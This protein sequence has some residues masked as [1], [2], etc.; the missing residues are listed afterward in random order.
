MSAMIPSPDELVERARQATGLDDF[1]PEGWKEGLERLHVAALSDLELDPAT[2]TRLENTIARRLNN[3][4]AIEAWYR[5][6]Q[7]PPEPVIGPI[8]IHGLPRTA[9]TALHYLL[10]IQP[11]FRYQRRWEID[12]PIRRE[13]TVS[14]LDDPRRQAALLAGGSGR[15]SVQH[16]S[17]V[18][19]PCDDNAILGLDFHNQELGLPLPSYT[20]WW[21]SASLATTYAYHERVLRLLH[22]GRPP[23]RWLVKA[24]YHNFHLGD[25]AA[26]YPEARFVWAHRDPAVA[27]PSACST[28]ITAQRHALPEQPPAPEWMGAFLLEHLAAGVSRAMA[29]RDE[30]GEDRFIDVHQADLEADPAGTAERIHAFLGVD[31]DDA[32]R[33][34]MVGWAIENRR[35]SRGAHRYSAEE[36]GLTEEKIRAEFAA[37][38]ER[39]DVT[40]EAG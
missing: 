37:Y 16:I 24:P 35:G 7:V 4:L 8:V 34:A 38:V 40:R 33:K 13:G 27:I 32:T 3:R 17:S 11:A 12:Q 21:R 15:G 10:S 29:D 1:G 2:A 36:Y 23:T 18:D 22:T 26:H 19:G 39:F 31:L 20:R 5:N 25:L 30:I 6:Q 14:E 9:T 28:V